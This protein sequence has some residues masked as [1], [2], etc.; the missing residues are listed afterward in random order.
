M[1]FGKLRSANIDILKEKYIMKKMLTLMA[2]LCLT[3]SVTA[4]GGTAVTDGGNA[5]NGD[6]VSAT[7]EAKT[8][9]K[10]DGIYGLNETVEFNSIKITAL[11]MKESKGKQFFEPEEG[12]VFVGVKFEIENISDEP[13]NMSSL[14][15]FDAYVDDIKCDYSFSA[16]VTF[17]EGTLSGEL[18]SGKKLVGWYPVEV[19]TDWQELELEV[20]P[21][22]LS[23]NSA[24]FAVAK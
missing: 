8:S 19:P 9:N 6:N 20:K 7:D 23:N 21:N 2:V 22:W 4:C 13:Q 16:A 14:L 24:K 1:V 11:D 12:K 3:A 15:L 17:D 5:G 10:K 18:A